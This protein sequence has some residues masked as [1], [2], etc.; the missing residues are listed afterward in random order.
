MGL[1]GD[2]M[3]AQRAFDLGLVNEL[4]DP[5]T[6]LEAGI[7]LA[8]RVASSAPLAVQKTRQLMIE[9]VHADDE[10]GMKASGE[11]IMAMAQTEDF[12]EGL[13]A[14]IEKRPPQ[15]KGR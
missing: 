12:G 6:A 4:A 7:A 5:G 13:T 2:P 9:L 14:F 10:E 11:G 3:P 15:W 8:G 1:T